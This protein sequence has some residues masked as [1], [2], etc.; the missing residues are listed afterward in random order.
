MSL[1]VARADGQPA[2][3]AHLGDGDVLA[4][5]EA[6]LVGPEGERLVLVVH[7]ELGG[8]DADHGVLRGG[9]VV[10]RCVEHTEARQP[11]S[12]SIVL[13]TGRPYALS[14][15][16]GIIARLAADGNEAR[17]CVGVIP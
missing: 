3:V 8:A 15:H 5:L 13:F 14:T 16:S 11:A 10:R 12:S 7:P 6:D 1:L 17:Y 2:E 4:D 9:S